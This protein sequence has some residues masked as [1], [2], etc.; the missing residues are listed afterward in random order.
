MR[1]G[2][3]VSSSR[4]V[5]RVPTCMHARCY[6]KHPDTPRYTRSAV[7]VAAQASV[8]S[9]SRPLHSNNTRIYCIWNSENQSH[10]IRNSS[11]SGYLAPG[12]KHTAVAAH[13]APTIINHQPG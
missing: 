13:H 7:L 9:Q 3:G 2:S 1:R 4:R 10:Q 6:S 11:M 8:R 5:T 12:Q